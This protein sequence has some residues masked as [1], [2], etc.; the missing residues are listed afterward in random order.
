MSQS[1]PGLPM[2]KPT[3][4]A[5]GA[6]SATEETPSTCLHLC[7]VCRSGGVHHL[8]PLGIHD[9]GSQ[10]CG[11]GLNDSSSSPGSPLTPKGRSG[12]VTA[13]LIEGGSSHNPRTHTHTPTRSPSPA[14]PDDDP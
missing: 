12:D 1:D 14:K 9:A 6:L 2:R 7:G 4:A 10:A 11:L 5:H 8:L 13:Y 3:V